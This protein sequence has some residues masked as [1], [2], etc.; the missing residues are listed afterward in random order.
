[1]F[2]VEVDSL[3]GYFAFDQKRKPE[4][5]KLDTLVRKTAPGLKRHFHAGTPPGEPGMRFKMI[6]YGPFLYRSATG[7]PV[8]WPI[9]GVALQKN[10]ISVYFA[11]YENGKP[12]T[13]AFAGK[14]GELRTGSN[15]FSFSCFD[16]LDVLQLSSLFAKAAH[17][18]ADNP[19][20]S[21]PNIIIP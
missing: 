17:L 15:N 8:Q 9:I 4:L 13:D 16:E 21:I 18:Y 14:L 2:K 19:L 12:I 7:R 11:P 6:G 20:A 1:M 10:Y 3:D 5:E